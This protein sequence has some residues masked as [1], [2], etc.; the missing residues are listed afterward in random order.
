MS[1]DADA[2]AVKGY[3]ATPLAGATLVITGEHGVLVAALAACL[4]RRGA[5]VLGTSPDNSDLE[6]LAIEHRPDVCIF[7]DGT[8][9]HDVSEMP[10]RLRRQLPGT[11]LLAF[12]SGS[13]G[14]AGES[15]VLDGS[16]PGGGGLDLLE[17]ILL[18]V[19]DRTGPTSSDG[20]AAAAHA[21]TPA[22]PPA[23]GRDALSAREAEVLDLLAG[24][25]SNKKIA[26]ELGISVN[27]VRTHVHNLMQKL[28]VQHRVEAALLSI[29]SGGD[30]PGNERR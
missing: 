13:N 27:T 16:V 6:Q 4:Q 21:S 8:E 24:G 9:G 5:E 28:R 12:A 19:L 17:V 25:A 1:T 22:P 30:G 11:K 20:G 26:E 2:E 18:H 14:P 10:Q 23:P 15:D 29:A 7:R 3:E